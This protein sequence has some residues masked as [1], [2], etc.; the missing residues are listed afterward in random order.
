[1]KLHIQDKSA[2]SL[3]VSYVLLVSIGLAIAGLVYGWLTFY[4]NIEEGEK[5]PDGVSLNIMGHSYYQQQP[6]S[7]G[8]I[9]LNL[10]LQNRGRFNIGG[11]LIRAHNRTG[12]T[13]GVFTLYNANQP[14]RYS[15]D[16]NASLKPNEEIKVEL[17]NTYLQKHITN[18]ICFVEVQPFIFDEYDKPIYC[19]QS[20]SRKIDC[21]D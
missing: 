3:I 18:R 6:T 4:V 13:V 19:T 17:N 2:I 8:E 10:T 1:M 21:F 14:D 15:L 12:A 5:C 16:I 7:G 20:A 9:E 11:F